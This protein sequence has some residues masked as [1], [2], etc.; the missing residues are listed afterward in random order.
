MTLEERLI[1]LRDQG[2]VPCISSR[3]KVWRAH[4]NGA[5]NFWEEA[6]TPGR[7]LELAVTQWERAGRPMDGYAAM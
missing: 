2:C 7:A 3:G 6:K 5:G 4:V 1:W